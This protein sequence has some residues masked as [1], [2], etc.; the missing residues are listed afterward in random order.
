MFITKHHYAVELSRLNNRVFFLNPPQ[1]DS[2]SWN[3]AKKRIRVTQS[4]VYPNLFLVDHELFFPYLLK[5]H[6]RWLY[7]ILIKKHLFEIE[8]QLGEKIDLVWSFDHLNICPL[9][10]FKNAFRIFHPVDDSTCPHSFRAAKTA[11]ILFTVTKEIVRKYNHYRVPKYLISHGVAEA[12]FEPAPLPVREQSQQLQVGL[13]GNWLRPDLDHSTLIRIIRE[14]AGVRFH[15]FGSYAMSDTNLGGG[16]HAHNEFIS[17]LQNFGNVKLHGAIVYTQL[18]AWLHQ[19]DAFLICYD[20]NKDQSNG[21]NY[22][23]IME[24][25]ST[26]KV[27]V[28]NNVSSYNNLP[29]IIQMV[30]ERDHNNELPGLFKK[31]IA[32]LAFHNSVQLSEKRK[33]YA[34]NNTYQMQIKRIEQI[35]YPSAKTEKLVVESPF[36]PNALAVQ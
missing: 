11:D 24:Y 20:V 35:L 6:C 3:K 16:H 33:A 13:S 12:F 15:F 8:Q 14:N 18:A 36:S 26:G 22:H 29:G 28:S 5:Y 10:Y 31:V 1:S 34:R 21:T 4:D 9:E 25:L 2:W 19:M 32:N 27:I 23:K 30:V 7:D 17:T